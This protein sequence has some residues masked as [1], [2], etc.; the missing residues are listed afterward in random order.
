MEEHCGQQEIFLSD[1]LLIPLLFGHQEAR[2]VSPQLDH[3]LVQQEAHSL[4][5]SIKPRVRS[6]HSL[7]VYKYTTYQYKYTNKLLTVLLYH[8]QVKI[9]LPTA[10]FYEQEFHTQIK[11][12]VRIG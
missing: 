5:K 6:L 7:K 10:K 2:L 3:H 4:K 8:A 12:V 11:G 9:L 1:S